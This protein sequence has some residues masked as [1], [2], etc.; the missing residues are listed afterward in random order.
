MTL[1]DFRYGARQLRHNPGFA[2]VAVLS[3][4]LGIGANTAI[5]QLVDAVRLRSLPVRAPEELSLIALPEG[6][7]RDGWFTGRSSRL[8]YA[9]WDEIRK[10]QQAFSGTLAWSATRF[11][12]SAG[13][14][15]RYAEGMFVSGGFF[16]TLGVEPILGRTFTEA[17]DQPVCSSAGAVISYS[18]WQR[19]FGGDAGALGRAVIIESRSF[20]VIGVTP[21]S[22]FGVEV[23]HQYDIALP[24]C[25]DTLLNPPA[26][27]KIAKPAAWWL[28]AMGRLKP[29][30]TTKR[31]NANLEAL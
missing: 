23:G 28:S 8:T 4:A 26:R 24:L 17:D 22:F 13:G 29:G 14:E 5:F 18:F 30:W 1:Q 25:A 9:L 2:L 15:P 16:Q 12:L 21:G 10:R 6:A 19:E 3:L 27:Q 11:D 20:P 7:M 31:A